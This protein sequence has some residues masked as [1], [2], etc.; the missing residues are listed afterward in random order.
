[1][2]SILQTSFLSELHD[3]LLNVP[4]IHF[5]FLSCYAVRISNGTQSIYKRQ[6]KLREAFS[7]SYWI[8]NMVHVLNITLNIHQEFECEECFWN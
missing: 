5:I 3:F 7:T 6:A 2:K 1:M 4:K 8:F